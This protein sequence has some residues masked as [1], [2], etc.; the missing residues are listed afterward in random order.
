MLTDDNI[1]ITS[2]KVCADIEPAQ[3]RGES[4][5]AANKKIIQNIKKQT[6]QYVKKT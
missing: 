1:F 3:L 2:D 4:K 5:T 6:H